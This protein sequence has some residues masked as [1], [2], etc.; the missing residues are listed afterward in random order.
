MQTRPIVV[1]GA[2]GA[3]AV[4]AVAAPPAADVSH[5]AGAGVRFRFRKRSGEGPGSGCTS[6]ENG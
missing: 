1:T 6:R 5:A 3:S 2:I 4:V